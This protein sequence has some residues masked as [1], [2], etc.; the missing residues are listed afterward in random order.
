[1]LEGSKERRLFVQWQSP[2][3]TDASRFPT[4]LWA[5]SSGASAA[6]RSLVFIPRLWRRLVLRNVCIYEPASKLGTPVKHGYSRFHVHR[7]ARCAQLTP[8]RRFPKTAY[9]AQD[10]VQHSFFDQKPARRPSL[11]SGT[12]GDTLRQTQP[13][14]YERLTDAA[15]RY[16]PSA[17]EDRLEPSSLLLRI[18][19]PLQASAFK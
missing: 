6:S 14:Q 12:C 10:M 19:L 18:R 16:T 7:C 17:C 11:I 4:P 15:T 1:M 13:T 5:Y 3:A 8:E 2:S 9:G